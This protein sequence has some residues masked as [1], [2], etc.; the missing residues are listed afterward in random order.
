MSN[1]T[2]T[3]LKPHRSAFV[4]TFGILSFVGNIFGIIFGPIAW[5]SG[6]RDLKEMDA[7]IMDNSGRALTQTGHVLGMIMTIFWALVFTVGFCFVGM[8][9][10]GISSAVDSL[11]S[12]Q[13]PNS[14]HDDPI[15]TFDYGEETM[16]MS[17]EAAE[18]GADY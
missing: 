17:G 9:F 5:I 13:S 6:S 3:R 12:Y 14:S 1:E 2:Q 18:T 11:D 7:G 15:P 16:D 10:M 8:A 4:F